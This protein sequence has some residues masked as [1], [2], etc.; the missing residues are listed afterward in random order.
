M[1][2]TIIHGAENLGLEPINEAK[3]GKESN[4]DQVLDICNKVYEIATYDITRV[5]VTI[6]KYSVN[7]PPYIRIDSSLQRKTKT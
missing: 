1:R 5:S 7:K 6:K 2:N 3:S 4:M